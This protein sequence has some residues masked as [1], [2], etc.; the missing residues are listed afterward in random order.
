MVVTVDGLENF[1]GCRLHSPSGQTVP[2]LDLLTF[3]L[4][5]L[6]F[7]LSPD[8]S[9]WPFT[10]HAPVS[11]RLSH[12]GDQHCT[13]HSK[14]VSAVPTEKD[15]IPLT[16]WQCLPNA[17]PGVAGLLCPSAH[18]VLMVNLP[19]PRTCRCTSAQLLP[20]WLAPA[21]TGTERY[22]SPGT[23]VRT[24]LCRPPWDPCQNV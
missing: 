1:Q 16:W 23:G 9:P 21:F 14:Y 18:C 24:S 20:Q 13:Q 6:Y 11:P 7:D 3:K 5:L 19:S 10:G 17:A 12:R 4:N 2:M 8:L 22:S 15:H